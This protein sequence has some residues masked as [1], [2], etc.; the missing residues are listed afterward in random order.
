MCTI[1]GCL[2]S[3]TLLYVG[4]LDNMSTKKPLLLRKKCS[5]CFSCWG[6]SLQTPPVVVLLLDPIWGTRRI[7]LVVKLGVMMSVV[8]TVKHLV[9]SL[10]ISFQPPKL[11][12]VFVCAPLTDTSSSFL[13]VDSVPTAVGLFQLLARRIGT[14]YQTNSQ[15]RRAVLIV[16]GSF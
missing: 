9:T 11:L 8:C 3:E 7:K 16:L 15:I 10:I 12:L 4:I 1:S 14:R 13:A 5:K 2:R 6:R